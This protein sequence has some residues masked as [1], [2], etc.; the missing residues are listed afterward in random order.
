MLGYAKCAVLGCKTNGQNNHN[1]HFHRFPADPEFCEVWARFTRRGNEFVAKTNMKICEDHFHPSCFKFTM[2]RKLFLLPQSVPTIFIS[3][4]TGESIVLTFDRDLFTYLEAE[5]Y[6]ISAY[7]KDA[8]EEDI[9]KVREKRLEEIKKLCRFCSEE[10]TVLQRVKVDKLKQ[11]S[12]IPTEIFKIFGTTSAY[13]DNL[14]EVICEECFQEIVSFDRFKKRCL[15]AQVAIVEELKDLD[16]RLQKLRGY[17]ADNSTD[18]DSKPTWSDSDDD[19]E[20]KTEK[21][22]SQN[23]DSPVKNEVSTEFVPVKFETVIIKCEKEESDN[24]D[25]FYYHSANFNDSYSPSFEISETTIKTVEIES[26]KII[27]SDDEEN[28]SFS[29]LVSQNCS[30]LETKK[31]VMDDEVNDD[32]ME[33]ADTPKRLNPRAMFEDVFYKPSKSGNEE[34]SNNIASQVIYECFNCRL[35]SFIS[36]LMS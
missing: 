12:I 15:K 1:K 22:D 19:R 2:T 8:R 18:W 4:T 23:L 27:S 30:D 33:T 14:S 28:T 5:K 16:K 3:P 20:D 6:L 13:N 31:E 35:V 9:A 10:L 17:N 21:V 29:A 36:Q 34:S 26:E 7:D 11:Y 25:D 32:L 24:D